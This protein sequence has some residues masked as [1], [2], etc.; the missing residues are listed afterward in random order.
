MTKGTEEPYRIMT[1]R[2]IYSM[3]GT[4]TPT[5][6]SDDYNTIKVLQSDGTWA[7]GLSMEVPGG[8]A[9][10]R[11]PSNQAMHIVVDGVKETTGI[12]D[13]IAAPV[14]ARGIYNLMGVKMQGE[15]SDLPAGIYI[16]NGKKAIKR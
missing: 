3:E 12:S 13:V 11:T 16:V 5:Q 1:S 9:Y 6:V 2:D 4:Y 7:N 15:W 8:S 14:V 10:F